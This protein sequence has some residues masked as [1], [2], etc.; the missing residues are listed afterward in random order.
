MF[1]IQALEEQ[2]S[3]AKCS[4]GVLERA[5]GVSYITSYLLLLF[6]WHFYHPGIEM[7]LVKLPIWGLDW[8]ALHSTHLELQ[9]GVAISCAVS[10]SNMS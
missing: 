9:A 10:G 2:Q 3:L 8:L 5:T 1:G 6:L 4:G 7:R